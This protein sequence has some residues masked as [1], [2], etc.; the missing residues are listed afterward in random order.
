ML[1]VAFSP[2]FISTTPSSQPTSE[3]S[4]WSDK[5]WFE[6][7]TLDNLAN[8]NGNNEVTTADGAIEP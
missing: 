1:R 5:V 2:S 3:V 7:H 4:Q 6:K 8:T